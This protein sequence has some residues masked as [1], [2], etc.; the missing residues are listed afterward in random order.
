M[1]YYNPTQSDIDAYK[2]MITQYGRGRAQD[3][4]YVYSQE[5]DGL[6]NFFSALVKNALPIIRKT[7]KAGATIAK[8]HLQKAATDI[9]TAGS[10]R[11]IDKVSGD[12]ISKIDNTSK[13][14]RKVKRRRRI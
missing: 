13:P 2:H 10:K 7:I 5:G 8:P 11:L 6:G 1:E 14:K 9:V 4:F 3:G 12:I